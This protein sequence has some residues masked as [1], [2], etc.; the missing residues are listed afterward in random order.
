MG[1]LASC[2]L[3]S[4]GPTIN[5][6]RGDN[7]SVAATLNNADVGCELEHS[8]SCIRAINMLEDKKLLVMLC[9]ETVQVISLCVVDFIHECCSFSLNCQ[10]SVV[11]NIVFATHALRRVT[12]SSLAWN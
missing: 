4:E 7:V 11:R 10:G 5:Q 9:K 12:G 6:N 1:S 3:K 2:A 8:N